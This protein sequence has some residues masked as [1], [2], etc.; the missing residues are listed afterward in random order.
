MVFD[1][2]ALKEGEPFSTTSSSSSSCEGEGGGVTLLHPSL[3]DQ[4]IPFARPLLTPSFLRKNV[5]HVDFHPTDPILVAPQLNKL[6][7]F[8]TD[9]KRKGEEEG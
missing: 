4:K 8:R 3:R 9:G 1:R 7:I 6:N 2:D 5:V